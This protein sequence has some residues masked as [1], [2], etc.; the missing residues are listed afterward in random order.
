MKTRTRKDTDG[1]TKRAAEIR[2][3]WSVQERR[4]RMGLPPDTPL[5]LKE[6]FLTARSSVWPTA[7]RSS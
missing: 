5:K 7:S 4:R 2:G 1:I 3:N 6:F